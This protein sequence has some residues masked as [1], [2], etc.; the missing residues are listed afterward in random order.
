MLKYQGDAGLIRRWDR[1]RAG[2]LGND[3]QRL[4]PQLYPIG[5]CQHNRVPQQLCFVFLDHT[6]YVFSNTPK[7]YSLYK[8]GP[9]LLLLREQNCV[10]LNVFFLRKGFVFCRKHYGVALNTFWSSAAPAV[11]LHPPPP[12]SLFCLLQAL[13]CGSQAILWTLKEPHLT[14]RMKPCDFIWVHA[15]WSPTSD[16][17]YLTVPMLCSSAQPLNQLLS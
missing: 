7:W 6:H 12:A 8:N 17:E 10:C 16:W 11:F 9:S 15:L 13:S 5:C 4:V 14:I 1:K 3:P 2:C